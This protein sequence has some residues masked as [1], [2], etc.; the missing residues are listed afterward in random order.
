MA[1]SAREAIDGQL[2]RAMIKASHDASHGTSRRLALRGGAC[3]SM[4]RCRMLS[5]GCRID[6]AP[7]T[8][9]D[10]GVVTPLSYRS[11]TLVG[12]HRVRPCGRSSGAQNHDLA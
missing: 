2:C 3:D 11:Q 6:P 1:R 5:V 7:V 10:E 12:C 4:S 8:V 9:L